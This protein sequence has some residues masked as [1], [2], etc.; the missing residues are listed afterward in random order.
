MM[1]MLGARDPAKG[2]KAAARLREEGLDVLPKMLDVSDELTV[3]H[4]AADIEEDP[5]RLDILVNNAAILYDTWQRAESADLEVVREAL[6]TNTLGAW[7]TSHAYLPL[8]RQSG[9]GRIVNVSSEGG[10]ISEMGG[11]ATAY[12]VSKA[13]STPS[14]GCS[15]PNCGVTASWSTPCARAGQPPP[16]AAEGVP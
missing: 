5:G 4:L 6:E 11:G 3:D 16:W 8:L 14:P 12:A 10:S 13:A 2:E 9:H 1:V 15:P 7:R